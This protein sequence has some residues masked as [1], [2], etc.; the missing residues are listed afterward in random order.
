MSRISQRDPPSNE[1]CHDCGGAW[2]SA[3]GSSRIETHF[4]L[5]TCKRNP[6][7]KA[8]EAHRRAKTDETIPA[9]TLN[10]KIATK[11]LRNI[12]YARFSEQI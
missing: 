8:F 11:I 10:P 1:L 3:L 4:D 12:I 9:G 7:L 5:A 6:T 2:A